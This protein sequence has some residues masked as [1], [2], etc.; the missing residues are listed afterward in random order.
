MITEKPQHMLNAHTWQA[1]SYMKVC[2][3]IK[4]TGKHLTGKKMT[5]KEEAENNAH[6]ERCSEVLTFYSIDFPVY[7]LAPT[8]QLQLFNQ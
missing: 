7:E 8:P 2:L 6:I 1:Y 5:A 3:E 4:A